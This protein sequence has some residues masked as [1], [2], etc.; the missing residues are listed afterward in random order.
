MSVQSVHPWFRPKVFLTGGKLYV[1]CSYLR[2]KRLS[3]SQF[4]RW[5]TV[6]AKHLKSEYDL[7]T[8]DLSLQP[9][10]MEEL[11]CMAYEIV[12]PEL[13]QLMMIKLMYF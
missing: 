13:D 10:M 3:D 9:C 12:F 1:T 2:D 5:K 7:D 11:E 4:T 8:R 6:L